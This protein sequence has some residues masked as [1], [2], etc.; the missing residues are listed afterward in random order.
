MTADSR[1]WTLRLVLGLT[2]LAVACKKDAA[3][4]P[5]GQ[6]MP[7]ADA[8][9]DELAA[10]QAELAR[11]AIELDAVG[12]VVVAR[13]KGTAAQEPGPSKDDIAPG[14]D[15]ELGRG[16][17]ERSTKVPADPAPRATNPKRAPA[18]P[19][20]PAVPGTSPDPASSSNTTYQ[21]ICALAEIACDLSGRICTLSEDHVGEARYEDACWNAEQQ[22]E[23]ASDAC[24]DCGTAC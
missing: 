21:R 9:F 18:S 10:A 22:C 13:A 3:S 1:I 17:R 14:A 8:R 4:A 5:P 6:A 11:N 15:D 16:R 19:E 20:P 23:Q 12:V 24:S 2:M 7:F